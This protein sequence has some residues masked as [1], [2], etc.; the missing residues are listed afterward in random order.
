M[1]LRCEGHTRLFQRQVQGFID[2][3]T[4]PR[5]DLLY[6]AVADCTL[7]VHLG[8]DEAFPH[9]HRTV[10]AAF[11][12]H[13]LN[14]ITGALVP[15]LGEEVYQHAFHR[16]VGGIVRYTPLVVFRALRGIEVSELPELR[17]HQ[18][19]LVVRQ[20]VQ[21]ILDFLGIHRHAGDQITDAFHYALLRPIKRRNEEVPGTNR[22]TLL[23][24]CP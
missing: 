4:H 12:Q 11:G 7:L 16:T 1:A 17:L 5:C 20:P 3:A 14:R 18:S 24:L 21:A 23:R 2:R 6:H 10:L 22:R 19:Q 13:R 9:P 15:L 8:A